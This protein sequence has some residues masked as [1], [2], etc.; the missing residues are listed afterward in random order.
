MSGGSPRILLDAVGQADWVPAGDRLAVT[1]FVEGRGRLEFPV[2][3]VV[4]ES[5]YSVEW[6][7]VSPRGDQVAFADHPI[8]EEGG[9]SIMVVGPSGKARTLSGGWFDLGLLA[10]APGGREIWFSGSRTGSRRNLWAVDLSGRLRML[11]EVPGSIDILDVSP[12]G[13][14][15][16]KQST[17]RAFV[18]GIPAGDTVARDLTWLDF[19][20]P[21]DLSKDGK[22][23]LLQ[24]WG[25]GGGPK[26]AVYQRRTDGSP[27][28]HLGEGFAFSLSPDEKWVLARLYTTPPRLVLLPTG[29]GE[30]KPVPTGDLLVHGGAFFPDGKRLLLIAQA[31][32]ENAFYA[33]DLSGGSAR[34]IAATG[35]A[36]A[37]RGLSRGLISPDGRFFARRGPADEALLLSLDTGEERPV[38]GIGPDEGLIRWSEDGRWIFVAARRG[39]TDVFSRLDPITGKREP[40]K[41]IQVSTDPVGLRNGTGPLQMTADGKLIFWGYQRYNDDLYLVEGLK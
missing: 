31:K 22:T 16:V 23:L 20:V 35:T 15:L 3:K 41:E 39:D 10:W 13:R 8:L 18:S 40:W 14:V 36:R 19:T 32:G 21:M 26:G 9:G 28:V 34:R 12:S 5:S 6:P 27:P 7:R 17:W 2:G 4:Y 33:L 38:A 37:A 1:H 25:E 30:P 29:A 24:E 11:D